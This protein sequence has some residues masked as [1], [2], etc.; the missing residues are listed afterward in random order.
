MPQTA[1]DPEIGRRIVAARNRRAVT[2]ADLAAHLG[3]HAQQLSRIEGGKAS[4]RAELLRDIARHPDVSG[5]ELLGL[6]A[7]PGQLLSVARGALDALEQLIRPGGPGSSP[8]AGPAAPAT[9][10]ASG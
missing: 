4:P 5:D 2:Q 9:P 1:I 7:E 6:P 10:P 3:M 8:P